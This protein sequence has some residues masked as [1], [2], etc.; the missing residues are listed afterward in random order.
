MNPDANLL[1]QWDSG[2]LTDLL[3][4]T[5]L[6]SV[7]RLLPAERAIVAIPARHHKGMEQEVN[8]EL[9]K[10][11]HV[12]L[13]LMGDEEAEFEV[14]KIKH[15]SIIIWVQNPHMGRH[16]DYHKLGTGYPKHIGQYMKPSIKI[17]DRQHTMFFAGQVTHQRREELAEVV[18][19]MEENDKSIMLLKTNGFTQGYEKSNYYAR[20]MTSKIAPAPSGA[21]VPDSFRLF[22]ALEC[23]TIPIGDLKTAKGDTMLYWDWLFNEAVP[24]PCVSN[25]N[26]LYGMIP[27]LLEDYP[28]NMHHI[29]AWWIK[30]KR[31][32]RNKIEEQ[33]YV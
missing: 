22:E 26:T 4:D 28:N 11:D 1:D 25:W 24:F 21:I 13:F 5:K 31:D 15:D 27:E 10:I 16:D 7:Y 8:R 9:N 2:L 19:A 17:Y 12:V 32:T 18:E 23:M 30:Y 6:K 14:E 29:T 20:M 3:G 33:Y